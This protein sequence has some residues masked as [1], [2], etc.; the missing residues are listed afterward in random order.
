MCVSKR[1]RGTP[2]PASHRSRQEAGQ[3]SSL[4]DG[5][6]SAVRY[7]RTLRS[8]PIERTG[9]VATESIE[10]EKIDHLVGCACVER[11]VQLV[12]DAT[13]G[14]PLRPGQSERGATEKRLHDLVDLCVELSSGNRIVDDAE[15][16]E[17]LG[18]KA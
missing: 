11:E 7:R 6:R 16:G 14:N 3:Q 12:G 2:S 10:L 1:A 8:R 13:V 18:G 9:V 15:L 4:R 5:D 17:V